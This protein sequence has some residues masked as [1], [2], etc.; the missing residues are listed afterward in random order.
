M[1]AI[2]SYESDPES[3]DKEEEIQET[4]D[5]IIKG[6]RK[7]TAMS[8][9][10]P[11]PT[12]AAIATTPERKL[13]S[14]ITSSTEYTVGSP[15][16]ETTAAEVKA[17]GDQCTYI[18]MRLT[19]HERLLLNVLE[20]ALEVCEY[21]DV[22]DV[23]FSHTRKSKSSR[24]IESLVDTLS[25]SCGLL[26]SNNLSKGEHMI[27]DRTLNDNVPIFRD[28]FEVGRRFKIMNPG[29]MRNTYGKLMYLLMDAES[30]NIKSELRVDFIKPI[31]TIANFLEAHG[32][33]EMMSDPLFKQSCIFPV[34]R[35]GQTLSPRGAKLLQETTV[36][37]R[38][39]ALIALKARYRSQTLSEDD[40]QRV[41]DSVG[42]NE[43]YRAFNVQPVE[44]MLRLLTTYFDP[45]KPE[46][47][48]ALDLRG[49]GRRMFSSAISS[50]Y[51]SGGF[52]TRYFGGGACLSHDHATQYTFVLQSLT[53][54]REIMSAMPKL[55]LFA[56]SDMITESYRLVDTGQ[57]YQ[58]LQSSPRVGNEMRRILNTVQHKCGSWVGLSVVHLGD[59][60]VP[61]AL[62]FIDKYTQVPRILKPIA[63]CIDNLPALVSDSAFHA[64]VSAEW[65]SIS[66]L[67][68]QILSDF[69]K[70]GYDG[71]G[72]DGGS[73][74]DGRL[75]SAWNWC[76]KLHKKPY[77][78]VFM[79]TGFQGFDGD[80]KE[81]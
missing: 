43:A 37:G 44:D 51:G 29:K 19:E 45:K 31:L 53:L 47:E 58:R 17:L 27:V 9:D 38:N 71:S 28:L 42:D 48:F 30:F 33:A 11:E 4:Y 76:S 49:S 22:V 63:Q 81:E 70:H 8:M 10:E 72:D 18:P 64:Y 46:G 5:D 12:V 50:L 35:H 62:V 60:D 36:V 25:I 65:G 75:T 61:N 20:N 59:R 32:G 57:G 66:A 6:A 1:E 41:V 79:F 34:S 15:I 14:G 3:T 77:Y 56:D 23:T 74:I 54:W 52:S 7:T 40:I 67:R 68:M 2:N 80:W 73:C 39:A 69:F 26:T 24:I 55:W 21:T 78:H 13:P 16:K